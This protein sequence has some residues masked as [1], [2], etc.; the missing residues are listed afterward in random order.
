M[1]RKVAGALKPTQEVKVD[2][3][4]WEIKTVSTF[5]TSELKFT[6]GTMFD[7]DSPDGR[8]LKV[9]KIV[10]KSRVCDVPMID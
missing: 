3:D 10:D 4:N 1:T 7:E 5:K 6:I 9:S 2:G 8:K